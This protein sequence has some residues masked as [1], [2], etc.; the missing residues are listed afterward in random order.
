M[1]FDKELFVNVAKSLI[2]SNYVLHSYAPN[3]GLDCATFIHYCLLF[4]GFDDAIDYPV[5]NA[6]FGLHKK[7]DTYLNKMEDYFTQVKEPLKGDLILLKYGKSY[8]HA[9]I[10]LDDGNIIH[11]C[12]GKGVVITPIESNRDQLYYRVE[13]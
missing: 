1:N 5:L 6:D 3:V 13:V 2:R 11:C 7:D 4:S 10:V 9:G 8:N 12:V